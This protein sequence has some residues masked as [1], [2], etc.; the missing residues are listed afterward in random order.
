M[1]TQPNG[2]GDDPQY[3]T[4]DTLLS[5]NQASTDSSGSI[6]FFT[7]DDQLALKNLLRSSSTEV[8]RQ[9]KTHKQKFKE[10]LMIG[11]EGVIDTFKL[12]SKGMLLK[13]DKGTQY[14]D[15]GIITINNYYISYISNFNPYEGD[16][17]KSIDQF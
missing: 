10:L 11:S 14:D 3:N 15:I 6:F 13:E 5:F 8:K 12:T 7:E 16:R 17:K 1:L 2:N 4:D 9:K